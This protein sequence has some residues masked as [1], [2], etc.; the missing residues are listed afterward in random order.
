MELI[1]HEITE[2]E[3]GFFLIRTCGG[4]NKICVHIHFIGWLQQVN[5]ADNKECSATG[6][7]QTLWQYLRVMRK[8][9]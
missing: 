6:Q 1:E 9:C 7:I 5:G 3:N 4:T 8:W 2:R